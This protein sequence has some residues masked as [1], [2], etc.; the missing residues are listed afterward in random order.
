M[1]Q[2][3]KRVGIAGMKAPARGHTEIYSLDGT[4]KVHIYIYL[5]IVSYLSINSHYH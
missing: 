1:K 4:T 3:R 5:L 2:T